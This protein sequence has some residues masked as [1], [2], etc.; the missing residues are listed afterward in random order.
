MAERKWDPT[1]KRLIEHS[2]CK[3]YYDNAKGSD[4]QIKKH[5]EDTRLKTQFEITLDENRKLAAAKK[6]SSEVAFAAVDQKQ[7]E[8]EDR[9][10]AAANKR[11][12]QDA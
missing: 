9:K 5:L 1:T 12:C 3:Y 4:Y 8:N 6:R 7:E 2:N 11:R 10:L